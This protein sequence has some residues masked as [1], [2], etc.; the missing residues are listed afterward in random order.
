MFYNL[1][2]RYMRHIW[3]GLSPSTSLAL[4]QYYVPRVP[5]YIV[6]G[7]NVFRDENMSPQ[8]DIYH[9]NMAQMIC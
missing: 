7:G 5:A 6:G 9:S 1:G 3:H 4:G 2:L 8:S